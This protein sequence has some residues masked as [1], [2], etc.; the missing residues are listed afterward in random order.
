MATSP[1]CEHVEVHNR[2]AKIHDRYDTDRLVSRSIRC[3]T[4]LIL[5]AVGPDQCPIRQH[6][7][8]SSAEVWRVPSL[9]IVPDAQPH[10]A[11]H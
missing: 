2:L 11:I 1:D 5:E 9:E 6:R 8:T 3:V 7:I 10:R 4:P